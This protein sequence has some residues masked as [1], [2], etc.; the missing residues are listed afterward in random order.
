MHRL[1]RGLGLAGLAVGLA[2]YPLALAVDRASGTEL[3]PVTAAD[4]ASVDANRGLWEL[5]GSPKKEVA[6]IYGTP[7]G[8]PERIVFADAAK[9]LHPKEDPSLALY[10]VAREDHPLQART[11]YY[12]ALPA[13]VGGIVAGA[14][15]LLLARR[16]AAKATAA[17]A[18]TPAP[19]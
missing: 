13:T 5:N 4:A 9:V 18:S 16:M 12:F 14:A 1:L 11:L 2:A 3:L 17:S 19:G 7:A 15:L 6:S 8:R 10:L